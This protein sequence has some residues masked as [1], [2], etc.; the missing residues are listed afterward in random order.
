MVIV[1]C[2]E[3]SDQHPLGYALADLS[4]VV[5]VRQNLGFNNWHE[6]V[7]LADSSIS[8]QD[9]RVLLDGQV[10]RASVADLQNGTPLSESASEFI[11]LLGH[12]WQRIK[13][14]RVVF[15]VGAW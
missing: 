15:V 9:P 4:R 3:S 13:P 7:F 10:S 14:L 1:K 6:P 5:T 11:E 8:S 12:G 2:L